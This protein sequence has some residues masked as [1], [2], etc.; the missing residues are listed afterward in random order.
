MFNQS[1]EAVQRR[2]IFR[3]RRKVNRRTSLGYVF[4]CETSFDI[5]VVWRDM[6][7]ERPYLP[8]RCFA[9]E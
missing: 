7:A 9:P 2:L 4:F 5:F 8:E 6:H 1:A 3:L